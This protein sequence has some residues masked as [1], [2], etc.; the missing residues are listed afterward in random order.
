[1]QT[2]LLASSLWIVIVISSI[3]TFLLILISFSHEIINFEEILYGKLAIID[4]GKGP[5]SLNFT[6]KTSLWIICSFSPQMFFKPFRLL[7][8]LLSFSIA[9]IELAP[10]IKIDLVKPPGPGP[11]SIISLF[12]Q[13]AVFAILFVIFRS[14]IKFWPNFLSGL[15]S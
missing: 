9:V 11:I 3:K 4:F 7:I 2:I 6:F 14:N 10:W 1:M 13:I 5:R 12:R 8:E 15:I